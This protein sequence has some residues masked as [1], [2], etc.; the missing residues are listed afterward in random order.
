M[1]VPLAFPGHTAPAAGFEVPLEMLAAFQRDPHP[2]VADQL[3]GQLG[4][5]APHV[6]AAH[7]AHGDHGLGSCTG[8]HL[9]VS[10]SA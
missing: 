1:A 6:V 7:R 8:L 10:E 9:S 3:V 5:D 4:L 2:V